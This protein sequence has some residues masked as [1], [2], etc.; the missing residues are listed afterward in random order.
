[1][2][3]EAPGTA[4]RSPNW[5]IGDRQVVGTTLG[6]SRLWFTIAQGVV[7]EI[8]CPRVDI[9]QLRDLGFIVSDG[10]GF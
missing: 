8:Y 10:K 9:P 1:M 5:C 2:E 6:P 7:N 4:G 3:S